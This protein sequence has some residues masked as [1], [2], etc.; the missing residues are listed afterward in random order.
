MA[1]S[2]AP[3]LPKALDMCGSLWMDGYSATDI[4]GTLFR[5]AKSLELSQHMKLDVIKVCTSRALLP[6]CVRVC[7]YLYVDGLEWE[8]CVG[9]C[10]GMRV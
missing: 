2:S 7:V 6:T 4:V 5:V 8:M 10:V 1:C 3:D 9:A